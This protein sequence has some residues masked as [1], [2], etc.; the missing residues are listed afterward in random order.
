VNR[1]NGLTELWMAFMLCA[2]T[3]T[4]AP[5]QT[6]T[7]LS[8]FNQTD[9]Q[10]PIYSGSLVQGL[11]GN[12]YGTTVSGGSN[13]DGTVFTVT[14]AGALTTLHNFRSAGGCSP[15]GG[16]VL[17]TSGSFYGVTSGCGANLEGTVFEITPKGVFTT[18]YN[19]CTQNNCADGSVPFGPLIQAANGN[20]YGTTFSGGANNKGTVFKITP[21]GTLTTLY[22][23]CMLANCTDGSQP[24]SGLV[25]G[26][27]GNFYGTTQFGGTGTGVLFG[28]T[29]G[30]VFKITPAGELT[31]LYSF[32]T[33][34]NCADGQGP[35]AGLVAGG[36]GTFYG[37]TYFG[38]TGDDGT[39]FEITEGGTFTNLYNFCTG[40]G[41]L[42]GADLRSALVLGTDGNFYG[43]A[44]EG[45]QGN[46]EGGTLGGTVFRMAP[47]GALT[48]LYSFCSQSSC[49]DGTNPNAG[50]VQD[51]DGDFYGTTYEG[52]TN[53][54]DGTVFKLST[55]L[56]PFVKTLPGGG[57]VGTR[58]AILGTSLTGATRVTFNG[59][60]ASFSVVSETYISA[61][62]PVGATTGTVS[63]VTPGGTL[64]SNVPFAIR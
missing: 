17:G 18:L 5:A 41:C 49:T 23:F 9:G 35:Q 27:D 6:F 10:W 3:A 37:T 34:T 16:L 28:N 20:F 2:A 47:G 26:S 30:T 48:L 33:Q 36:H 53:K 39:I 63:V 24:V 38:G 25:Q 4:L 57:S 1:Q 44:S 13:D 58:V 14:R 46:Y 61:T 22:S 15:Y 43:T 19:F 42:T 32:C 62:I 29:G 21:S 59:V 64:K 8:N 60:A 51:T 55:G 52:G 40:G 50:V 7:N 45:G 54:A 12:L 31:T 11:N 56:A